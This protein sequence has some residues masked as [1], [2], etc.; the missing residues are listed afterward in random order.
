MGF[1]SDIGSALF[2]GGDNAPEAAMK[3]YNQI[4]GIYQKYLSPFIGQGQQISGE[5][6]QRLNGL[7]NNPTGFVDGIMSHYKASPQFKNQVAAATTGANNA[8]A[9]GGTLGTGEEQ[10]QLGGQITQLSDADQQQ[11]LQNA[12]R[13]YMQ[14]LGQYGQFAGQLEGQG[15]GASGQM[16]NG[17]SQNLRDQAGLSYQQKED[18]DKGIQGVGSFIGSM[19]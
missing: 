1:F 19:F 5:Y 10:K 12:M 15:Y 13:P 14:A 6:Q 11:Y 7:M 2:G 16:A 8:S 9:A 18:E 17:L 3:Y 4:P